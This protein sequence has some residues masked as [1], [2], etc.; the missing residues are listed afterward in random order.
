MRVRVTRRQFVYQAACTAVMAQ[1]SRTWARGTEKYDLIIRGGR[2]IDPAARLDGI[3]DVAIAQGRI[4]AVSANIPG[5]AAETVDAR[6]KLVVPGL[7]DIH[8][9]IT[10]AENGEKATETVLKDGVTGWLDAGSAGADQIAERVPIARSSRQPG[11]LLINIGRKGILGREGDTV[12]LKNADVAAARDAIAKNRDFIVGI[13][14]RLSR[15]AAGKNDYEVL[16]RAQEAAKAFN[17]PV[18]IHIG[19]S[20]SPL[21]KL[22]SLMQRGDIV[23]H[24]FAPAPNGIVDEKGKI[25]PEVL[26]ARRRGV[27]FDV[28]NGLAG[29]IRW[30]VVETVMNEKFFPDVI[31]T[32]WTDRSPTNAVGNIENCMSKMLGYGMSVP[33]VIACNTVNAAKTFPIFKDRGTLKVGAPAD[34]AI[35]ELREGTFEFIDNYGGKITGRQKLFPSQTVLGGKL[36]AT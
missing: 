9:H 27:W 35:I 33:Q 13:K 31:S 30:D 4:A 14:A 11:R 2:V 10:M 28:G 19:Q 36:V 18:M 3:R 23:T 1:A 26:A 8:T 29:H 20:E 24:T 6:G 7:I 22:L 21:P 17:L 12:D 15:S 34:V 16:R 25:L 5:D 32:D